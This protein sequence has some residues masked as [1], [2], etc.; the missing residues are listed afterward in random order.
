MNFNLL[1][2]VPLF[3]GLPDGVLEQIAS[4]MTLCEFPARSIIMREGEPGDDFYIILTGHIEVIK[5]FGTPD[6]HM[7]AARGEGEFFGELS[8]LN[9]DGLRTASIRTHSATHM[10]RMSHKDFHNLLHEHADLAIQM[11]RVLGARLTDAHNM[12]IQ[13]LHD[14]NL[15]LQEAYDELKTAHLQIVEKERLEKELQ[16][17]RQIQMSIVP[18]S[19]PALSGYDFGA[20]MQPARAVGGDFY[21]IFKLDKHRAGIVIGDVTDKGV[22]S[23]LLMA[24]T[25]ALIYAEARR[26]DD[27]VEVMRR[28]NTY[29]MEMNSTHLFV[30]ATYGILDV[31]TNYFNY[32][33]AGHE[34]PLFQQKAMSEDPLP[35]RKGQPL[36]L[37]ANPIFDEQSISLD[38]GSTLLLYTDGLTDCRNPEG[39]FFGIERVRQS[40]LTLS[41]FSA[42]GIC[43]QMWQGLENFKDTAQQDDDVTLVIIKNYL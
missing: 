3:V 20:T 26:C 10:W 11:V 12:S 40:L 31:R 8:L 33:R 39:E 7:V 34:L 18:N 21:D 42:Q 37:L 19:L 14:K 32:A 41:D 16:V 38:E 17:A 4:R 9:P 13:E 24:Q 2:K 43:D 22:P 27:A 6:E 1:K 35:W 36:G 29:L 5:A 25:H 28:V 15:E 30:T 23:A